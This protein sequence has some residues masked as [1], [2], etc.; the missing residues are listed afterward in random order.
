MK[1]TPLENIKFDG[2]MN[3]ISDNQD[4]ENVVKFDWRGTLAEYNTET[5]ELTLVFENIMIVPWER[6]PN[7]AASFLKWISQCHTHSNYEGSP[8]PGNFMR[9]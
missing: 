6:N 3:Y 7:D 8:A 5:K 1:I 4:N 9:S 2:F